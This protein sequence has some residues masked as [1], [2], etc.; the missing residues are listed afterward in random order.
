MR[1][2]GSAMPV[3]RPAVTPLRAA[4]R[5]VPGVG[6]GQRAGSGRRQ[7]PEPVA[8]RPRSPITAVKLSP[9]RP[10]P[11][12]YGAGVCGTVTLTPDHQS[13]ILAA[14]ASWGSA[15]GLWRNRPP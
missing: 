6:G 2:L 15:V 11:E 5:P 9:P 14:E 1:V 13:S 4:L 12:A 7:A 8:A 3:S 10:P